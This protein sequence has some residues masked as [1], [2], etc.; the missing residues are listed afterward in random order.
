[1][2]ESDSVLHAVTERFPEWEASIRRRYENDSEFQ[3]VCRDYA[4]ACRAL[5]YWRAI[6][7]ESVERIAEQYRDLLRELG[8][9]ILEILQ[10][11]GDRSEK[12][13]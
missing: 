8:A 2:T 4:E 10:E 9:E 5:D 3:E 12:G 1:M 11:V 13:P 7:E 6:S